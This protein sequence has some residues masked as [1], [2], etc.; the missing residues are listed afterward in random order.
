MGYIY[1]DNEMFMMAGDGDGEETN[2]GAADDRFGLLM[3]MDYGGCAV[4]KQGQ[5]DNS[6]CA[7]I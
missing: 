5:S 2:H 6:N 3:E 1:E 7:A 4:I